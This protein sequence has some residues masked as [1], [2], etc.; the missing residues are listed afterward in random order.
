MSQPGKDAAR[1]GE[2]SYVWRAGQDRRLD[3]IREWG[4]LAAARRVLDVGTGLGL[5]LNRMRAVGPRIE[6]AAGT[7]YE[8]ERAAEAAMQNLVTVAAEPLPFPDDF[9][10][11]VLSHEVMEHVGDDRVAAREIVRVLRPGGRA[12]FFV[13]NRLWPFETHGIY[14]G[15]RYYFGN[16]FGVPYL[17]NAL[18]D[19][20][21]PHVRAYT[22]WSLRALFE[23]LPVTVV[24]H[25]QIYPGY[26]KLARRRPALGHVIR[27]TTYALEST[28]LRAFGLS[29]LLVV[30]KSGSG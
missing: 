18:R 2:P 13:P 27:G 7:E 26:D 11:L 25:T 10:D 4:Q 1:L 20:L 17:P 29:H 9:F 22:A 3:M 30:E 24:H 28:P 15:G 14:W 8:Y 16:K 5:Y 23:G 21:A 19:R 6:L 12:V